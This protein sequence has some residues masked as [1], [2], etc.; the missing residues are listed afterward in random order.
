MTRLS[1]VIPTYQ[2]P[3]WLA[4]AV[5]SLGAQTRLPDEVL[6]VVRDTDSPTHEAVAQLRDR[7]LPFPLRRVD[8]HEPGFMPPVR[9]GMRA[10]DGDIVAVLDDDAEALR[11]WADRLLAHY[12]DPTVGGVGGRCIN[13]TGDVPTPVGTVKRVG[14]TTWRGQ[15][16]GQMFQRPLFTKPIDVDFLLGGCM[17]YRCCVARKLCFDMELNRDVS[18]NYEVDLG[19]Q[20]REMGWRLVFDPAIAVRHY[21]APRS[22][23]GTRKVDNTEGVFWYAHN[24]MR[25]VLRRLRGSRRVLGAAWRVA[26]GERRAPGVVAWALAPLVRHIGFEG[27]LARAALSGRLLAVTG[28]LRPAAR[29]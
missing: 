21:T 9:E 17:S 1:V 3:E 27:S 2:R 5:M 26:V 6:A 22:V 18:F 25:I 12:A 20:V 7:G 28:L 15:F 16:V 29:R 4:R 24:E 19:L 10:A 14:Y 13:M 8:V 23:V 11:D